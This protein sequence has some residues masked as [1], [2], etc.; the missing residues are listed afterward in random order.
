MGC[1][2]HGNQCGGQTWQGATCCVP[3]L[4]CEPQSQWYSKCVVD[5]DS[6]YACSQLNQQCGGRTW[7]GF[8]CCAPGLKC[9]ESNA[10]YSQCRLMEDPPSLMSLSSL[11]KQQPRL[12]KNRRSMALAFTERWSHVQRHTANAQ[13]TT[14]TASAN[15]EL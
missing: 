15:M 10:W 12:R 3:G 2:Q 11:G 14:N 5:D 13:N 9:E 6:T 8:T 4:K 1:A 7:G